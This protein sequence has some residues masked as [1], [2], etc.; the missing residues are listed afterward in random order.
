MA[1]P[2]QPLITRDLAIKAALVI[3]DRDGLDAFGLE[4]LATELGVKAPSLYYHFEGKADLL[5][6]ITRH[7]VFQAPV[8]PEPRPDRWVEWYVDISLS[9]RRSIMLHPNAAPLLLQFLP[10]RWT[11]STYERGTQLM[12][13]AGVPV[14]LQAMIQIGLENLVFGWALFSASRTSNGEPFLFPGIDPDRD[15]ALL[16]ALEANPWDDEGL[17][18]ET[19]RSFLRGA[20]GAK[21]PVKGKRRH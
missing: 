2:T 3:I 18:A 12:S 19:V 11:L 20:V 6:D 8:P 14:E 10:R 16:R 4:R 7:L 1:R 17:F 9:F 13:R 21:L 5:A 15:P